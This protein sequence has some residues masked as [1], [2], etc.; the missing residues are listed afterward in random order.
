MK[1]TIRQSSGDQFDITV[2]AGATVSDLKKA[3]ES[4]CQLPPESQRLIYK[5]EC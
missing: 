4:G 2:G 1:I 3:C 5:G